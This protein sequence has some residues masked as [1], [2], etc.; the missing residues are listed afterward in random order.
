M[1]HGTPIV[2]TSFLWK[3]VA[4]LG[5]QLG[6]LPQQRP[7]LGLPEGLGEVSPTCRLG[8]AGYAHDLPN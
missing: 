4:I 8:Y 6:R 7:S 5:L 1:T 2:S 3:I